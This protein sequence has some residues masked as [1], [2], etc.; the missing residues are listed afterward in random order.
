MLD[1]AHY[2]A[3]I[4]GFGKAGKTLAGAFSSKDWKVAL[5]EE[6]TNMYGGTCINVACIPTKLL[7]HDA[8]EGKEYSAAIE[9]KFNT[10][11]KLNK[12]NYHSVADLDNAKVIDGRAKF[13]NEKEIEVSKKDGGT[14][15][16]TANKIFINT[17]ATSVIPPLEGNMDAEKIY[18]ST[19]LLNE[20]KLPETLT[21]VGGGYIGLEF[22]TMY[23]AFGAT[24]N[25]IVPD[26]GILKNEDKEIKDEITRDMKESGINFIFGKKAEKVADNGSDITV[27]LS[28]GEA[29]TSNAVLFATGRKANTEG[30]GLENTKIDTD[31]RG[32]IVVDEHLQ[33]SVDNIYAV[34]DVKGGMQFTYTSLDDFRVVKSHLLEDG[35]YTS[36]DRKNIQYTKFID[37]PFSKVGYTLDEAKEA[38]FNAQEK[39]MLMSGHP[40]SHINN[41]LRGI[42]KAVVD[43]ESGEILGAHLYGVNSE[44]LIN[45][46]KLAMDHDI[47]YGY[48]RD[49][50]YNH[51]GMSEAFNNLFNI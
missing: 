44:E 36:D 19:S 29:V 46:V 47:P 43:T 12:K 22:A 32:A 21:I 40:R 28:G 49:M 45:M 39:S 30:L 3:L 9:R 15:S 18:T 51:P 50:M 26:D 17:G 31:D 38:G 27:S 33:T 25:I 13:V 35:S 34:G 8:L 20:E 4:I 37:P 11:E 23:N 24:V 48:L 7:M 41:E 16:I 14:E 2:D 5:V 10:I 1:L 42:F 6:E